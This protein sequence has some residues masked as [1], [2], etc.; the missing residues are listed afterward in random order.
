MN[1]VI[2]TP[3]DLLSI[4]LSMV[5]I[6]VEWQHRQKRETNTNIDDYTANFGVVPLVHAQI[7]EDLQ[8]TEIDG[9]LID[10]TIP[11]GCVSIEMFLLS[12]YF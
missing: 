7:W 12:F 1:A 11:K 10:T 8:T 6:D 3:E 2:Y 5:G 9:A 4:G